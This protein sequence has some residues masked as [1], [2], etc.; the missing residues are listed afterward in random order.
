MYA[1]VHVICYLV[2]IRGSST[3]ALGL[4]LLKVNVEFVESHNIVP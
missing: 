3:K 1:E 4:R 2:D